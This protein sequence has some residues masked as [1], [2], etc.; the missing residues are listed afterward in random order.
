M[1]TEFAT[2]FSLSSMASF[3][4][5]LIA[6]IGA[7]CT[8]IEIFNVKDVEGLNSV[9]NVCLL[10]ML[11]FVQILKGFNIFDIEAWLPVLVIILIQVAIGVIIGYAISYITCSESNVRKFLITTL[12]FTQTKTLQ[13]LVVDTFANA[14]EKI[15]VISGQE[16]AVNARDRA[17]NYVLLSFLIEN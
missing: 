13:L 9:I 8:Y 11:M 17:L 3:H 2:Y 1:E 10:P 15:S 7:F 5:F 14:M 16:F 6:L 12:S 4:L